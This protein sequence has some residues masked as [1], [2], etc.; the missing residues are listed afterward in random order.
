MLFLNQVSF[1]LQFSPPTSR[2]GLGRSVSVSF[3][4][5]HGRVYRDTR[6]SVPA[7]LEGSVFPLHPRVS[8]YPWTSE[9]L[10]TEGSSQG[11][12][13]DPESGVSHPP[14]PTPNLVGPPA[15]AAG[16]GRGAPFQ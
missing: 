15:P 9:P 7:E 13:R 1:Q 14:A 16:R 6:C 8:P 12:Q 10:G 11:S 4:R 5:A 3:P 2:A